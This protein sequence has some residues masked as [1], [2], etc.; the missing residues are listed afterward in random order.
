MKTY[1]AALVLLLALFNTSRAKEN[2]SNEFNQAVLEELRAIRTS[3]DQ[4]VKELE[5]LRKK[6][7]ARTD[8]SDQSTDWTPHSGN[9]ADLEKL[10]KIELP[11]NSSPEQVRDYIREI[12]FASRGQNTFSSRDPQIAM[13]IKVGR[14]NLPLLIE[15]LSLS[16]GPMND[17]HII[18]AIVI[19]ADDD[20][21]S[22]IL[23][24]LPIHHDLITAIVENGWEEDA[25]NTLLAEL[26]NIG[27]YLPLE[28]V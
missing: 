23:E 25:R 15:T 17:Y 12:V 19:L 14:E 13:L 21:K 3:L 2:N 6:D 16:S 7:A 8:L 9:V 24:A 26:K 28:G 22:L 5:Q 11:H 1:L 18:R 27:Q 20:S 4:I 10:N